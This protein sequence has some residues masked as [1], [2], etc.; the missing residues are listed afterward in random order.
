[1]TTYACLH[2]DLCRSCHMDCPHAGGITAHVGVS[3][4]PARAAKPRH[5]QQ[6]VMARVI[7]SCDRERNGTAPS[8]LGGRITS[9]W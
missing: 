3:P 7:W 5:T 4:R 2:P 9:G 1:M 6:R 8:L